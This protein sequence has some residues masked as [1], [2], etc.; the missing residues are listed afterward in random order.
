MAGPTRSRGRFSSLLPVTVRGGCG[1]RFHGP[2]RRHRRSARHRPAAAGLGPTA[3][4]QHRPAGPLSRVNRS[5]VLPDGSRS[6]WPAWVV[7]AFRPPQPARARRG[8]LGSARLGSGPAA[9]VAQHAAGAEVGTPDAARDG[10]RGDGALGVLGRLAHRGVALVAHLR[11]VGGDRGHE[12]GAVTD[13]EELGAARLHRRRRV[14]PRARPVIHRWPAG[15]ARRRGWPRTGGRFVRGV[16]SRR[17]GR[18][19]GRV[20]GRGR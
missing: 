3:G 19:R 15:S 16:R 7:P 13:G 2:G 5:T 17:S 20:R 6:P 9:A 11:L 4:D 1:R 12:G 10:V 8:P 18:R 14:T